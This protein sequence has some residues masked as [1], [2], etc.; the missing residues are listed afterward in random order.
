MHS[1][2]CRRALG[3]MM[4]NLGVYLEQHQITSLPAAARNLWGNPGQEIVQ[5]GCRGRCYVC[6]RGRSRRPGNL[7]GSAITHDQGV[8]HFA[9]QKGLRQRAPRL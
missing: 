4:D 9:L 8:G 6:L 3:K 2:I 5:P 1:A 7:Q